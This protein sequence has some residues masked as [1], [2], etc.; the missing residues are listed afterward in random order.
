MLSEDKSI[1]Q[2]II[3][4]LEGDFE[5]TKN[6]TFKLENNCLKVILNV[7]SGISLIL[8]TIFLNEEIISKK[9]FFQKMQFSLKIKEDLMQTTEKNILELNEEIQKNLKKSNFM[10]KQF[11]EEKSQIF[12]K[13]TEILN[14]KKKTIISLKKKIE[15]ED[16]DEREKD[17]SLLKSKELNFYFTSSFLR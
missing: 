2:D 9:E 10:K 16:I 6:K 7:K 8:L 17:T 15:G 1:I 13:F 12:M 5:K 3:N 14:E 4:F 11:E